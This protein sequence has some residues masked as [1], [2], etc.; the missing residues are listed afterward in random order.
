M[1]TPDDRRVAGPYVT[2]CCSLPR[3]EVIGPAGAVVEEK[4]G[5]E[6]DNQT[7]VSYT[8]LSPGPFQFNSM[9][10]LDPTRLAPDVCEPGSEFGSRMLETAPNCTKLFCAR[11]GTLSLNV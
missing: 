2:S 10:V 8:V 5:R 7:G 4:G 11:I 1:V 6:T 3:D 9:K